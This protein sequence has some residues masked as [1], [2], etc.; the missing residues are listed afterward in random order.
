MCNKIEIFNGLF[1]N[2]ETPMFIYDLGGEL[3]W[4]SKPAD[5]VIAKDENIVE[6]LCNGIANVCAESGNVENC[7]GGVFR[8]AELDGENYVIIELKNVNPVRELISNADVSEY[9]KSSDAAFREGISTVVNACE[10]LSKLFSPGKK[11]KGD[12]FI[13]EIMR[14][15]CL[16]TRNVEICSNMV[17]ALESD[18]NEFQYADLDVLLK[19]F[20]FEASKAL[21]LQGSVVYRGGC[22]GLCVKT[23]RIMMTTFLLVVMRRILHMDECKPLIAISGE[24]AEDNTIILTLKN[25]RSETETPMEEHQIRLHDELCGIIGE[26]IDADYS[27]K[28]GCAVIRM[29]NEE[30]DDRSKVMGTVSCLNKGLLSPFI[31][32]ISDMLDF[33]YLPY[34][35][36]MK[37]LPQK[38]INL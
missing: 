32:L 28:N 10:C 11:I 12:N 20:A 14:S 19:N 24:C 33:K 18:K 29:T 37:R 6:N 16:M 30:C 5:A 9:I 27:Y 4:K 25:E 15:C 38:N 8:R 34:T 17:T 13:A 7:P 35:E 2:T 26:K 22:E 36:I 23:D 21:E 3:V 1:G 31:V